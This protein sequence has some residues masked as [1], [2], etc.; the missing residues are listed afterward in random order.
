MEGAASTPPEGKPTLWVHARAANHVLSAI[1]SLATC[2][3]YLWSH[4]RVHDDL[5]NN[6]A[7]VDVVRWGAC[8]WIGSGGTRVAVAMAGC[9]FKR[10][11]EWVTRCRPSL[12]FLRQKWRG[13]REELDPL[14]AE[15]PFRAQR[16]GQ[17]RPAPF[18]A[19]RYDPAN[20]RAIEAKA[21]ELNEPLNGRGKASAASKLWAELSSANKEHWTEIAKQQAATKTGIDNGAEGAVWGL[22]GPVV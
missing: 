15:P 3:G 8:G 14:E 1:M 10:M 2:R 18:F 17:P 19:F 20:Q 21:A 5:V 16:Q 13:A 12:C 4:D 7:S 9:W 22:V 11:P 6:I